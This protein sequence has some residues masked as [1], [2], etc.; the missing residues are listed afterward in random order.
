M[1]LETILTF[2]AAIKGSDWRGLL[3]DVFALLVMSG[4]IASA[5]VFCVGLAPNLR[6]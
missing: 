5:F 6:L 2:L 3:E 4:F 1:T